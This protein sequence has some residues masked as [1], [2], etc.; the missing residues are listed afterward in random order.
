VQQGTAEGTFVRDLIDATKAEVGATCRQCGSHRV[1][2]VFRKGF[3]QIKIYPLFG[4]YPWKCRQCKGHS[5]LKMRKFPSSSTK[6]FSDS[7][8][9]H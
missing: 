2:R 4:Y 8:S 1:Y 3:L 9:W 5:M 6:K 7:E